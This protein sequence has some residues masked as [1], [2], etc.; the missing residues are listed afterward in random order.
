MREETDAP[1]VREPLTPQFLHDSTMAALGAYDA[2]ATT[3]AE[4]APLMDAVAT[5]LRMAHRQWFQAAEEQEA[6]HAE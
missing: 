6:P 1:V 4:L 3:R 2:T 5:V